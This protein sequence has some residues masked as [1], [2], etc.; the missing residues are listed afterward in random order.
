VVKTS[1]GLS[2]NGVT[3]TVTPAPTISSI[4]PTSGPVGTVVTITGT[5]FGSPQGNG[6]VRFN[7][8]QATQINSWTAS[9]IKAVVPTGAAT[10]PI[11]VTAPGGVSSNSKTFTVTSH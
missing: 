2:S 11:I 6:F 4:S 3:F 9:S 8:T 7:G 1:A 10:G 5:N